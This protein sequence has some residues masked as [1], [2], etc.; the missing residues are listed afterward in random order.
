MDFVE[1]SAFAFAFGVLGNMVASVLEYGLDKGWE[2]AFG[3]PD[4]PSISINPKSERQ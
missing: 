4:R 1:I 3:K 2:V